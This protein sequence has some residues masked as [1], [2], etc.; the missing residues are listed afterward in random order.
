MRMRKRVHGYLVRLVVAIAACS[1]ALTVVGCDSGGGESDTDLSG[2]ADLGSDD[3]GALDDGA[4]TA[5]ATGVT[6][7]DPI[8]DEVVIESW[9]VGPDCAFDEELAGK[10][11]NKHLENVS[12][13]T[14][15]GDRYD[16][17]QNCGQPDKKVVWVFFVTE[18]C[19][20]CEGYAH[21]VEEYYDMFKDDGLEIMWIMGEDANEQPVT[22]EWCEKFVK[23][24]D[25]SFTVLTD[26][27][28]YQAQSSFPY[29]GGALPHQYIVD[30]TNMELVFERGGV[31][32]DAE[33]VIWDMLGVDAPE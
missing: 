1:L 29:N 13:L 12:L 14:Y 30:A 6:D 19:G 9:A 15:Q 24:K 21:I 8:E 17:H 3:S 18:W 26:F 23:Q 2:G 32:E 16:L 4:A 20:A 33:Q 27:K 25:L 5:S 10:G 11:L 7:E 31:G 28:Y 22:A